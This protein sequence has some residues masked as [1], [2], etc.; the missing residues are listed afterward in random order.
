MVPALEELQKSRGEAQDHFIPG[1]SAKCRDA[2]KRM[3]CKAE[4][5]E[6]QI[7]P[8]QRRPCMTQNSKDQQESAK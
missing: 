6:A 1:Q 2:V 5:K 7:P 8:S 4:G 3:F